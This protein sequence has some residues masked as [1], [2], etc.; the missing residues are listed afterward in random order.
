M[1]SIYHVFTHLN[2]VSLAA[3]CPTRSH[4]PHQV[5]HLVR[6]LGISE[7]PAFWAELEEDLFE[8]QPAAFL[9]EAQVCF[10]KGGVVW[11]ALEG[12]FGKSILA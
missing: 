4:L 7:I 5:N 8:N 12:P 6:Q 10:A 1:K 11:V 2:T 3:I 9:E